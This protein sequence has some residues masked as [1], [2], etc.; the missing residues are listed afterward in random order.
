MTHGGPDEV[1]GV[2]GPQGSSGGFPWSHPTCALPNSPRNFP[3]S[4]PNETWL[5][6]SVR[7][8]AFAHTNYGHC[9]IT[10]ML[11]D[12]GWEVNRMRVLRILSEE[13]FLRPAHFPRSRLRENGF[14][15]GERPNERR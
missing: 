2:P 5:R 10:S 7:G 4:C 6:R 1:A 11:Q 13:Q 15:S 8:V 3:S 14:L 12:R 9:R